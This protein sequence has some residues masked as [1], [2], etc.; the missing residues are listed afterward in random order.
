MDAQN[1]GRLRKRSA[2]LLIV[3]LSG[4]LAGAFAVR[5]GDN[6]LSFNQPKSVSKLPA[7]L[8]YS[9]VEQV[10][11]KLRQDYDGELTT[12]Q[13]LD[14]LKKGLAEATG[15][16]YTN[17]FTKEE[18]EEFDGEVNGT[19]SGIGAELQ[20][21][22]GVVIIATPLAGFPAEKAGLKARDIIL[23]IDDQDA[24]SLSVSQAVD[25]IRGPKGSAVKLTVLRDNSQQLDFSITRDTIS[26][27][28]VTYKVEDGIGYLT[29]VRFGEDTAA[30]AKEA[31][32]KFLEAGV[33][34]VIV[35]VRNNP[36]GYLDQAVGV[37][38]LW[39]AK[40]Q[41]VVEE[42]RGS[43]VTRTDRATG[44]DELKDVKTV[45]LVNGGSASASEILAGALKDTCKAKLIG[46][47]TFGK[48]S[49]QQLENFPGGAAL[50]VTI[51]KWYTP[52]GKNINKE[53]IEPD[54]DITI[55]DEQQK[56]GQDP[57]LDAA[58]A[59]FN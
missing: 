51:A 40:G 53:G 42:R 22:N 13:V 6:Y 11:D 9:T 23:K 45:V 17:Y 52:K 36:G 34:G 16:P 58:K 29:I 49:V 54:T 2:A 59:I 46:E 50:K 38:S 3:F 56:S 44:G 20:Q 18:N 35:D 8:D 32:D 1:S 33:K 19:F 21:D 12:Q 41:T 47:K 4:M 14:G 55:S 48:G 30:L 26:I 24:T 25:K 27:P 57:Q 5:F 43:V 28:S 15:D 31:A 37:A 7:N 10:Y 39:I